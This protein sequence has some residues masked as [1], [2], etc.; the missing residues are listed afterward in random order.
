MSDYI[1]ALKIELEG[2][3][4]RGLKDRA[5]QVRKILAD[6]GVSSEETS[7]I[8]VASIEPEAERAIVRKARKRK[9]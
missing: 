7:E 1:E 4:R 8:E 2:Y 3:V 9:A 6:A 5:D